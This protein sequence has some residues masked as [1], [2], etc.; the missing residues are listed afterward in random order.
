MPSD[1]LS[2]CRLIALVA[3]LL[4]IPLAANAGLPAGQVL[5]SS[6]NATAV[7]AAAAVRHLQAG[8]DVYEG[9][10]LQTAANSRM[11]IKMQDGALLVLHPET[12][13]LLHTYQ[14]DTRSADM[15]IRLELIHGSVRTLSGDAGQA[16][17]EAFRLNT[18]IAAIG[19]RGT[20][21]TTQ[22]QA[23][24]TRVVLHSGAIVLAPL[25]DVCSANTL[26]ACVND[27][28]LELDEV[29]FR[30]AELRLGDTQPR[31]I[32]PEQAPA[33]E[34]LNTGDSRDLLLLNNTFAQSGSP[35]P[36]DNIH[37]G[38]WASIELPQVPRFD[39]LMAQGKK[40]VF[41]NDLFV[42]F[43]DGYQQ[44]GQG[45][46]AFRLEHA[47]AYRVDQTSLQPVSV[48]AGQ[49]QLD[50]DNRRFTTSLTA[51]LETPLSLNASG[52][53]THQGYLLGETGSMAVKGVLTLD[54]QQAGYLFSH[55]L[56]GNTSLQG[57]TQ[58]RKH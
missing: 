5:M 28:S 25:D 30:A 2:P 31:P 33:A 20:D 43:R 11:Q 46:A 51:N 34:P 29:R 8:S 48:S 1:Y 24:L 12:E 39:E 57:A 53:L 13:I 47:Q 19:I 45:Q 56:D 50:F 49:L 54:N 41:A 23:D 40:N 42:L 38:R 36:A 44:L 15:A 6:G 14:T 52:R 7:T 26:G 17:P 3:L 16:R 55:P 58:W 32:E 9:E 4:C 37:W 18:P 22:S 21:F 35:A 27:N 10:R